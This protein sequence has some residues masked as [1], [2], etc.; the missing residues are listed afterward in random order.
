MP[1]VNEPDVPDG[2]SLQ[3]LISELATIR[4]EMLAAAGRVP[5][6]VHPS[7]RESAVNLLHYLALRHRDLRPLQARL[8]VL[9]L[10]SLGRSESHVLASID[11][12]LGTLCKLTGTTWEEGDE[13]VGALQF[14]RG[15]ELLE[16]HTRALLGP[17]PVGRN[18]R[19]MVTMPSEAATN[20][21]LVRDLVQAGMDCMRINCAHDSAIEWGLMIDNLRRAEEELGRSCRVSMDLAGPKLRTGQIEGGLAVARCRPTRNAFGEVTRAARLWLSPRDNPA[22]SPTP[23]DLCLQVDAGWLAALAPGDEVCLTDTRGAHRRMRVLD[24]APSGVWLE[25][26]KTAYFSPDVVLHHH[27]A[28]GKDCQTPVYGVPCIEAAIT[29]APGD[30]LILKPGQEPGRAAIR[31]SGGALLTPASISCTLPEVLA[32]VNTGEEVWFDDGKIGGEIESICDGQ[33]YVR[34]HHTGPDGSKLR[35]DKGIN[36]PGSRLDLAAMTGKDVLDLDFV[37]RRAQMVAL[38]FANTVDDVEAL[39]SRLLAFGEDVPAIVLKIETVAGF[40]N[41]PAMLLAAMAAPVCGVMIAR[42]DLAVEAGFER[43]AEVQEEILWLCEAAHVPVIWATQVLE[44]QAKTGAPTR[45]EITDAAMGHRAEC[46][47][48]NKGPHIHETVRTLDNIL[49]R[50]QGHQFKKQAML[51]ELSL[52]GAFSLGG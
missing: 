16:E 29:L 48:L 36:F 37:A 49:R 26:L 21:P 9:G 47:M 7:Q 10:S 19:I 2:K 31:D 11:A 43:L 51:R 44:T 33:L 3:A 5:G 42:G 40:H 17:P 18:P 24:A 32:C 4:R 50:M 35:A 38:S 12:V 20:Y 34:I 27:R 8:A 15:G 30:L 22:A 45:A 1:Q 6:S 25:G 39:K 14:R 52:A 13:L 41:L 46:V 23:A 28:N